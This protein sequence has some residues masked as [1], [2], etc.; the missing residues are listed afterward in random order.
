MA[1]DIDFDKHNNL[2][3]VTGD[4]SA[5][6]RR[7]RRERLRPVQRPEDRREADRAR[8]ERHGRHVHAHVQRPDDRRRSRSTR[9]PRRSRRRSE[10]LGNIG[11][12]EHPG[13][14]A[15][16]STRR[17][18]TC[19]FRGHVRGARTSDPDHR[20][21]DRPDRTTPTARSASATAQE[22]D[23][24]A[25]APH[26][27]LT[28]PLRA[29]HQR[30]ARQGP[31]DPRQGRD[32]TAGGL[33]QGRPRL[34]RRLHD[35]GRQ[36]A[37]RSSPASPQAEDEAPEVYA[38]GFRNPFRIQVD[39]NDVA[40]VSDYSPDS[41]MPQQFRGPAG[42]RAATRSSAS[43]PTTAGR[44][45]TSPTCSA[46][47]RNV[48]LPGVRSGTTTAGT[49]PTARRSRTTAAGATHPERRRTG[50]LEGGPA[51][52]PGLAGDAGADRLRTSGTRTATTTRRLRSARRA[53]ATTRP[54][55]RPPIAPGSTT[56]CPRLFPELYT[57]GVGPH[58]IAKYH[59]DPANPNPKKFPPYYDNSVDPRRV[60]AGHA[61]RGQARLAE[62][63]LQDQP[64]PGLRPGE[65]SPT[66]AFQFECDNPMD[67]QFGSRRRRSTC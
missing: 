33:E 2:W 37:S 20:R 42:R 53:S 32:I 21:R 66:P 48:E 17:T 60:H 59:Y 22:G 38:M 15:A 56:P 36:P 14:A 25:S 5:G 31:A 46:Y 10:A 4:D 64:V 49:P 54:T 8:H 50:T 7:R 24:G 30:P 6:R 23:A 16:R 45:A 12:D 26:R 63:H 18:C 27:R 43:R 9:P 55:R 62:P 35:P 28:R 39:E 13:D 3:L 61:A 1:G 57:G 58:G 44:T 67:M 51:V 65:P 29:E 34:R 11:T 41:Q 47:Y 19:L 40:Y 52:E